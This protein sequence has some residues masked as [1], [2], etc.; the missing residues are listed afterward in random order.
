MNL[1]G[2]SLINPSRRWRRLVDQYLQDF[3]F[4]REQFTQ[5]MEILESEPDPACA[6]RSLKRDR[7]DLFKL[8]LD[9]YRKA[10]FLK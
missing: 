9:S 5:M 6:V 7:P 8:F 2:V 10:H 4:T 1:K 3:G